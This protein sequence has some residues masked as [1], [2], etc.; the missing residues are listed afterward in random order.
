[1]WIIVLR[2]CDQL[3]NTVYIFTEFLKFIMFNVINLKK[4]KTNTFHYGVRISSLI[5]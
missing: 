4:E 2:L 3:L 1:M 5:K